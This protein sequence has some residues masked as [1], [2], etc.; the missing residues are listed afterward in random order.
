MTVTAQDAASH[1]ASFDDAALRVWVD[2]GWAVDALLGRQLREHDDLD[3]ALDIRD[4]GD[5]SEAAASLGF[6]QTGGDGPHNVVLCDATG[7]RLDVHLF[8]RD[9]DGAVVGGIAYPTES[10]T[11][12]GLIGGRTVRCISAPFMVEFLEPYLETHAWKY[13]PAV[14]ALCAAFNL[15]RPLGLIALREAEP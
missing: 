5:F 13:V 11:G 10:L 15:P 4:F 14:E 12:T 1:Y 6:A 7:R 8:I 3:L 2:G 9:D